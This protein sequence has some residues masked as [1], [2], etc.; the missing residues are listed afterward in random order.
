MQVAKLSLSRRIVDEE[1]MDRFFASSDLSDLYNFN[2][3]GQL[4][5][6]ESIGYTNSLD[7]QDQML[8]E[9]AVSTKNWIGSYR[10]H[11]SLLQSRPEEYLENSEREAIWKIFEE[12]KKRSQDSQ[13]VKK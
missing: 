3:D 11:D 2:P 7:P 13:E 8:V 9:L 10:E 5:L 6:P 1:E 12:T 4:F